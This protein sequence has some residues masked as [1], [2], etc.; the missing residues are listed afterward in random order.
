MRRAVGGAVLAAFVLWVVDGSLRRVAADWSIEGQ[1]AGITDGG[2]AW[3]SLGQAYRGAPGAWNREPGWD[4]P[5][6]A[7]E[8]RMLSI[9][10]SEESGLVVAHDDRVW[11]RT[12]SGWH[13]MPPLPTEPVG[14][15]ATSFGHAKQTFR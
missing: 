14:V 7:S 9:S 2:V 5:V 3:N 15:E 4:L 12:S 8:V 6:A 13:A 1:V 10:A 11:L